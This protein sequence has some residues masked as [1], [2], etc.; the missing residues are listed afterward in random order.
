MLDREE[1]IEQ[2]HLFQLLHERGGGEF[3]IQELLEQLRHEVLATTKLPMAMEYMLTEVKHSGLLGPAMHQLGHYFTPF[4]TFLIDRSESDTG[5]F[6]MNRALQIMESEAKY[7]IKDA[8]TAGMFLF[9]FEVLCRNRLS[10]DQGLTA[11]SGDPI[12]DSQ[13]SSWILGLRAQVGLVD[14]A[15]L[16]FLASE[17]YRYKLE[18][19][20]QSADGKGPFLFGDKEGR[21]AL[22]N[23]RKDPLYLFSALQR[24]LGYP[25]VP[26]PLPVDHAQEIIPQMARR[27]ERL[28]ARIQLMEEERRSSLDITK[29]YEK[30]KHQLKLPDV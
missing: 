7:R 22:A 8:T 20:G 15:D 9:Q 13:W 26:K 3:P 6:T 25:P 30:N 17:H 2:A 27:I 19:A 5:R 14:F 16:L 24:H 1:Y 10:Y 29:F 12:Y 11:I 23:R 21:I 28:E 4:Q 18:Q